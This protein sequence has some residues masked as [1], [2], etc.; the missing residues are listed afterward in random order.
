MPEQKTRLTRPI[1]P[2]PDAIRARLE[3]DDLLADFFDRPA[4]QQNDYLGWIDRAKRESTRTKRL[5][6]M[7]DELRVGGV[8]MKMPHLPSRKD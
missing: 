3:K 7:L 2:M 1:H 4:Y 5:E 6:Q 8:Y